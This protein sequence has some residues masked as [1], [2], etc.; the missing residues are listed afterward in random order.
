METWSSSVIRQLCTLFTDFLIRHESD[1]RF[2]LQVG[3]LNT[4][5]L[6]IVEIAPKGLDSLHPQKTTDK[7][8]C[9]THSIRNASMGTNRFSYFVDQ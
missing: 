9:Q 8:E 1:R 3:Y 2:I 6:R 5:S 4:V 7:V